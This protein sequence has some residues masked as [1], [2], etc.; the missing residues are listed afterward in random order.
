MAEGGLRH[1]GKHED[2]SGD[3]VAT[4]AETPQ[5]VQAPAIQGGSYWLTRVAFVRALGFVYFVA[6]LV[7]LNQNKAL[8]GSRGLLPIY[9]YLKRLRVHYSFPAN[10]STSWELFSTAPTLFWWISEQYI[11]LVLDAVAYVGLAL[12]AALVVLGAGNAL[13]FAAAWV[14][15]HSLVNVGQ[16]WYSFGWESQLLETGFLAIFLCPVLSMKQLPH[17]TPTPWTVVW[18]Y[19][20]LLF[21]IMLGAGLIKIRGDHCWRD[22]TCMNYHY[23]TQPVPNPLSYYL[24]QM[25]EVMHMAETMA[26][27]IIE[28]I[29]PF[30]IFLPRPFRITCGLL[31]I[32]FQVVLILSGNLSFLNWLTILP[33]IFCFDDKFFAFLFPDK[34]K[35]QITTLKGDC[36]RT[37]G[38][39]IR[40]ASNVALALLLAYLS[41][42][43]VQNLFSQRQVM[44]TSFNSL[45]I[46]NTYGAFGSITKD[47]TEV[48]IEGTYNFTTGEEGLV[49]WQEIEFNC[50]PGGTSRQPCFIS[51]YHYRIDWLL[52]FAAFQDYQHNPWLVHL[53]GKLLMGDP[54]VNDLVAY[55][56]F[57]DKPPKSVRV[58]HYRYKYTRIGSVEAKQGYWWQRTLIDHYLPMVTTKQ[59]KP[60]VE[61]QGWKWLST[62]QARPE[63]YKPV[64]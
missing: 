7:A 57:R 54:L 10:A 2:I 41:I 35:T 14:L 11:D 5:S 59:L 6:F 58:L 16:Q 49:H 27:H 38:Q 34:T 18:A 1:R 25:P 22:L 12:S 61:G 62:K 50:K 4:E 42:P 51:P 26:N 13:I 8:L 37:A 55:N 28:L 9:S 63:M 52:W 3:A 15:Y 20:W 60:I 43:V 40:Q 29:V 23:E 21:R 48:V 32:L 31:Q 17:H 30:L 47:R 45:R 24:H 44:N 64:Q 56:P 53:V 39:C 46:L 33:A 19:R 36:P